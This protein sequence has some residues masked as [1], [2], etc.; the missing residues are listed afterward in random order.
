MANSAGGDQLLTTELPIAESSCSQ[1][2]I[3]NADQICGEGYLS[4]VFEKTTGIAFPMTLFTISRGTFLT[5]SQFAL[6]P[7]ATFVILNGLTVAVCDALCT[8]Y[9]HF[10]LRNGNECRCGN[11]K[12]DSVSSQSS[13]LCNVPCSGDISQICGAPNYVNLYTRPCDNPLVERVKNTGFENGVAF[14][15][16]TPSSSLIQWNTPNIRPNRGSRSARIVSKSPSAQLTLAQTF[17][18]CPDEAYTVVF[19]AAQ[20]ANSGCSA[21]ISM[22]G[23]DMVGGS[24]IS[25]WSL[26]SAKFV[27]G[28]VN[29]A[30][31]T[32]KITCAGSRNLKTM[33]L[34]NVSVKP[35][36]SST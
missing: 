4:N 33:Y 25:V 5:V 12:I 7:E 27:A 23:Q 30:T 14:W 31:L 6:I 1:P 32:V 24:T 10:S 34:D 15:T 22:N 35:F 13:N 18:V 17:Q 28:L 11:A 3:G 2:C 26:F 29:Q 8:T 9:L 20:E 21:R 36:V 19:V 16:A